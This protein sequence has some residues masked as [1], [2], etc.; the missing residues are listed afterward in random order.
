MQQESNAYKDLA[1][2]FHMA[3]TELKEMVPDQVMGME[4]L[5]NLFQQAGD[6]PEEGRKVAWIGFSTP[7]EIFWAMDIVPIADTVFGGMLA[8]DPEA[9]IKYL[10]LSEEYIPGYICSTNR[11]PLAIALSGDVPLPD[12]YVVQ[13]NPC[14]SLL[15]TNCVVADLVKR[16]FF[17]I[18]SPYVTS[19]RGLQYVANDLKKLV[20]FLEG[21]T[22]EKLDLDKLREIMQHSNR[23]HQYLCQLN[24]MT[25]Q[26]PCG[27]S[28]QEGA[29]LYALV[30]QLAGTAELSDCLQKH[31]E[32][33]QL[34]APLKAAAGKERIRLVWPYLAAYNYGPLLAW[35]EE[36]FG[37][38]S[39]TYML[40]RMEV[41]PAEDLSDYDSIM[42]ALARKS[43]NM[44]MT[45]EVRGPWDTY[46]TSAIQMVKDYKADA[47]IFGGHIACKSNWAMAKLARDR[48]YEEL[49]I[50]TLIL[51]IDV[52]DPRVISPESLQ[53]CL[54]EFVT[55]VQ[56]EKAR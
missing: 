48:I 8:S 32:R 19:E 56:K 2:L 45:R 5:G 36:I 14:D 49:G 22:G 10:E 16:P 7:P 23:A 37:A 41:E 25:K 31:Y 53:D 42:L 51:E 18:T 34:R 50:R 28:M 1:N 30:T 6:A 27:F 47:A 35:L 40:Q 21:Y 3:S 46:L 12:F 20:A 54:A 29:L 11:I 26:V 17:G 39:I 15:S 55:I 9:A 33:A 43:L 24:E 13:N 44:P 38:V 52:L 4:L